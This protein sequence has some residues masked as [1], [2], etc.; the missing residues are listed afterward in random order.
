VTQ[1]P[2]ST[3]SINSTGSAREP[4]CAVTAEPTTL[5]DTP[6]AESGVGQDQQSGPNA[7]P[8]NDRRPET[9]TTASEGQSCL[10]CGGP[11]RGRRRNGYCGDRCRMRAARMADSA[12]IETFVALLASVESVIGAVREELSTKL[13][14]GSTSPEQVP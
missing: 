8:D 4:L 3:H 14:R 6:L 13:K 10:Q 1:H 7:H 9:R 12:R 5:I 2:S 11:V